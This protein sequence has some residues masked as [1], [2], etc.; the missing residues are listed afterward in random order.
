MLDIPGFAQYHVGSLCEVRLP[1]RSAVLVS[2]RVKLAM[3]LQG[4]PDNL[5]VPVLGNYRVGSPR[6]VGLWSFQSHVEL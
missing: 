1:S 5:D 2:S 6:D 3:F 4:I